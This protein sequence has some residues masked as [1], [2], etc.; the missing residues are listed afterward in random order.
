MDKYYRTMYK[1]LHIYKRYHVSYRYFKKASLKKYR[2][3]RKGLEQ[4]V[5]QIVLLGKFE[6]NKSQKKII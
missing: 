3:F 2:E 5:R 6:S 4:G 1:L